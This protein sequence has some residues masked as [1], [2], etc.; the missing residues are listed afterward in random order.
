[1]FCLFIK[2][3]GTSAAATLPEVCYHDVLCHKC[4]CVD[5]FEYEAL[6]VVRATDGI[7]NIVKSVFP[8]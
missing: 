5:I 6:F 4:K 3:K 7:I 2:A 8:P 1:M